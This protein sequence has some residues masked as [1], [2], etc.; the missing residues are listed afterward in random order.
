MVDT[1]DVARKFRR[2]QFGWF[3]F[4]MRTSPVD[5]KRQAIASRCFETLY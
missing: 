4:D 5:A 3:P 1:I 2:F